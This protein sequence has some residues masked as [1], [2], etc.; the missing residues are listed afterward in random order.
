MSHGIFKSCPRCGQ[1]LYSDMRFCYCCLE[2]QPPLSEVETVYHEVVNT[3]DAS[4]STVSK[5]DPEKIAF[6][7]LARHYADLYFTE[8]G[9]ARNKINSMMEAEGYSLEA[10]AAA[11]LTDVRNHVQ[12]DLDLAYDRFGERSFDGETC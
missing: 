2:E 4:L 5:T 8:D 7:A 11:I 1:R 6:A 12:A 10:T 9:L 3:L